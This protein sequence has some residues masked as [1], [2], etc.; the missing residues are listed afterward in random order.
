MF[1]QHNL[2]NKI[3]M[4]QEGVNV[5]CTP[6]KRYNSGLSS[7]RVFLRQIS[8]S[9]LDGSFVMIHLVFFVDTGKMRGFVQFV[10]HH[11]IIP[12]GRQG[13][14]VWFLGLFGTN[15]FSS[16]GEGDTYIPY[17]SWSSHLNV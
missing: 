1:S 6:K 9:L 4:C 10:R 15:L 14:W 8:D 3:T 12:V 13:V 7:T 16:D 11:H 2:L 17:L 5:I